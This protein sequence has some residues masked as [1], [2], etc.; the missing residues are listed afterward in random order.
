MLDSTVADLVNATESRH[1]GSITAALF[2]Q[3]FVPPQQSWAH[4]DLY[5]WNDSRKPGKP[6]GGDAQCLRG[7]FAYLADRYSK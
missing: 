7:V 2:L 4:F 5:A 6:A 3:R 1:A